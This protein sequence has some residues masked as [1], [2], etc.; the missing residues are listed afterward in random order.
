M[1]IHIY[2]I[3]NTRLIAETLSFEISYCKP[4]TL[5][6]YKIVLQEILSLMTSEI[7]SIANV[8]TINCHKHKI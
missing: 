4:S 2:K 6:F 3:H 7:I 1:P 5:F 8:K